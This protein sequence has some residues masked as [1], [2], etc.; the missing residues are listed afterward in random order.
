MKK[1]AV[2]FAASV[3]AIAAV[4]YAG[5]YSAFTQVQT[6]NGTNG[7]TYNSG[8]PAA[9]D[10][11]GVVVSST[12][13]PIQNYAKVSARCSSTNTFLNASDISWLRCQHL[14]QDPNSVPGAS[15]SGAGTTFVWKRCPQFDIE[16]DGG[17]SGKNIALN[18][19][20]LEFTVGPLPLGIKGEAYSWTGENLQQSGAALDA[21][22]GV[23]VE[24]YAPVL[25][26]AASNL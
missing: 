1:L 6:G 4:A 9:G 7:M 5:G 10:G 2:V 8:S 24:L 12:G 21:G 26:T 22:V 17:Q 15:G 20:T 14:G 19:N 16:I 3:L 18:V 25:P 13:L 23:A 11:A